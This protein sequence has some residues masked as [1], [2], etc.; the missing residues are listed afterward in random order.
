MLVVVKWQCLLLSIKKHKRYII[1]ASKKAIYSNDGGWICD[2]G[3]WTTG[4]DEKH[5]PLVIAHREVY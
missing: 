3:N 1:K 5:I 4:D 2:C